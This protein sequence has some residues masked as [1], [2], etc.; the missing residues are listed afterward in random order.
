VNDVKAIGAVETDFKLRFNSVVKEV[1][2]GNVT[3]RRRAGD[4]LRQIIR[5]FSYRAYEEGLREGGVFEPPTED[6][7]AEIEAFIKDQS[8]YVSGLTDVLIKQDGITDD[9]FKQKAGQWFGKSIKPMYTAGMVSANANQ[10]ME[11][12]GDDGLES[13]STCTRLKGQRHR[14]KDWQRKELVPQENTEN[15]EC[16][17]WECQHYL[18]AVASKARGG[19]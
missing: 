14:L 4:I 1:R 6:E 18:E 2:D 12:V 17:G 9:Q 8:Q 11:F 19:W 15:Y 13:C 5:T 16:G 3:D 7:R 10:M